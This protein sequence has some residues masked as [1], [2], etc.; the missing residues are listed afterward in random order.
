MIEGPIQNQ[1]ES[2]VIEKSHCKTKEKSIKFVKSDSN[3]IFDKDIR[4]AYPIPTK[5]S[6]TSKTKHSQKPKLL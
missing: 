3:K 2:Y 4:L 1:L 5:L 6:T